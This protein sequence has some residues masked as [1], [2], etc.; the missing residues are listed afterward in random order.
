MKRCKLIKKYTRK[1]TIVLY[2]HFDEKK[3]ELRKI[4]LQN[5]QEFVKQYALPKVMVFNDRSVQHIF[6]RKNPAVILY[7]D[8]KSVNLRY[9]NKYMTLHY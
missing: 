1:G 3:N 4:N 6:Q 5:I 2:K 7:A 8:N 9:H